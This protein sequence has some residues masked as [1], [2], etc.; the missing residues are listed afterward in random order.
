MT[1]KDFA[2]LANTVRCLDLPDE[3]KRIVA[4]AIGKVCEHSNALFQW[5]RF[6]EAVFP[7]K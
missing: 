6:M 5:D 4:L 1:R 2:L 3:E 7:K